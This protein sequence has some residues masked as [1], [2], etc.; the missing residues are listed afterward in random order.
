[1][2][3]IN[4]FNRYYGHCGSLDMPPYVWVDTGK[5]TALPDRQEGVDRN[6]DPYG[7]YRKGPIG[8]DFHIDEVLPHL[9]E[10]SIAYVK[11]RA[12]TQNP[13]FFTCPC[14]LR[15]PRSCPSRPT[16]EPAR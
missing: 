9:F 5:V 10:K 8:S 14:P 1:M 7:W 13:S 6:K 2:V 11:E 16:K 3:R 4:G 12:K 15:I